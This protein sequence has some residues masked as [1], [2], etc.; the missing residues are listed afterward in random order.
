MRTQTIYLLGMIPLGLAY[1][2]VKAALGGPA[3]VAS[4]VVYAL[5]L[6][7][8]AERFGTGANRRLL[9]GVPMSAMGRAQT[10]SLDVAKG[11]KADV[12]SRPAAGRLAPW[13]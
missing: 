7:F 8:A 6:R 4:V 11:W 5:A 3:L 1:Y 12:G 13:T 2:P 10:L 9:W